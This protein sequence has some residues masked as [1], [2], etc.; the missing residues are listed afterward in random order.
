MPEY[1]FRKPDGTTTTRVYTMAEAP[2]IGDTV[3]IGGEPCVRLPSTGVDVAR[4]PGFTPFESITL[5]KNIPWLK[6]GTRGRPQ[7]RT[8][9][10]LDRV[11]KELGYAME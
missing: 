1:L 3:A 4:L 11:N 9:Q 8:R 2:A 10:E 5:P 7:I 6:K